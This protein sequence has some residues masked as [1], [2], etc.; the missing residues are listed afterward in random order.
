MIR[1]AVRSPAQNAHSIDVNGPHVLGV[2]P[3]TNAVP[4]SVV[5]SLIETSAYL[6]RAILVCK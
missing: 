3:P 1:F 6:E 5:V 4:V 2:E